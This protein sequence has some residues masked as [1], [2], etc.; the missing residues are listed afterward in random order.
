MS[1]LTDALRALLPADAA[2]RRNTSANGSRL[3]VSRY[4]RR[5]QSS[6]RMWSGPL[7]P[8]SA[9]GCCGS[10]T[11][12]SCGDGSSDGSELDGAREVRFLASAQVI[13]GG[14]E[15]VDFHAVKA[16]L[17]PKKVKLDPSAPLFHH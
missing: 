8:P 16:S 1:A 6:D 10:A 7:A 5:L 9:E 12:S 13:G 4:V 3:G 2:T 17:R 11:D 14:E 15:E